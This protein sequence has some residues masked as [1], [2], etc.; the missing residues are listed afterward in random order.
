MMFEELSKDFE[1]TPADRK[2]INNLKSNKDWKKFC[3]FVERYVLKL[4][5]NL[6]AGSESESG[7]RYKEMD[8]LAGFTYYWR[9]LVNVDTDK[10]EEK[11]NE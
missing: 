2:A 10:E 11:E 5:Y 7:M 9:K 3:E 6:S 8:K 1:T 4:T